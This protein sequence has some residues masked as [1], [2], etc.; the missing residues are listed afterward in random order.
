MVINERSKGVYIMSKSDDQYTEKY[1]N[2]KELP[3][4]TRIGVFL[5]LIAIKLVE[6]WQYAHQFEGDLKELQDLLRGKVAK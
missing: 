3:V 5:I 6:P 2:T 4:R 1:W